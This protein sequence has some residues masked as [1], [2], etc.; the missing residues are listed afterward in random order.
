MHTTTAVLS[1]EAEDAELA[2]EIQALQGSGQPLKPGP[3]DQGTPLPNITPLNIFNCLHTLP[4]KRDFII[5]GYI[6]AG[7]CGLLIA[8]GGT[9]KT[10]MSMLMAMCIA[11]GR[12]VGPFEVP[13]ARKVIVV[14][15]EDPGSDIHKRIYDIHQEYNFSKEESA[16]IAE[17]LIIFAGL[18][19]IGPLMKLEDR[20]P[21]RTICA[22]WLAVEIERHDPGL[23]ILDTK[24]RL[25]KLQ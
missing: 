19:I 5:H 8:P 18:G 24:A 10:F 14:N 7:V 15:V 20:N 22:E 13:K 12:T 6:P 9:G 25:A 4:P 23:V 2:R 16:L 3:R 17:N 1:N 21:K 11:C